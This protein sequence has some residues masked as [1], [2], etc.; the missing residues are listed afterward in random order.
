MSAA[1]PVVLYRDEHLLIIDKASGVPLFADRGGAEPLWP[2]LQALGPVRQVH[3][4]DKGTS[5]VLA[6]ALSRSCQQLL[7]RAFGAHEVGKFYIAGV[8]GRLTL[9]GSGRI[10]LPLR[11]GRKSRYRVAGARERIRRDGNRWVLPGAVDPDGKASSTRFRQLARRGARSWLLVRPLTGRTHQIRVHLAWI[12][13]PL[14]GDHLYG[15]P[16]ADDQ[17]WPRLALHAHALT[18]PT[19][20][21]GRR[22]F[23]APVPGDL[24][25]PG[26]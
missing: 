22:T 16:D 2:Q 21:G 23:R 3:R 6:V 13:H 4:I 18:L 19:V 7:T 1:P 12:G 25:M 11:P 20:N 26:R 8:A 5:G 24:R 17:R 9:R 14:L 10:D 15:R